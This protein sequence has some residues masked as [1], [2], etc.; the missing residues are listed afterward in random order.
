MA[1]VLGYVYPVLAALLNSVRG[2][3]VLLHSFQGNMLG[4]GNVQ[5]KCLDGAAI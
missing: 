4:R 1:Y 3:I 5:D 2:I